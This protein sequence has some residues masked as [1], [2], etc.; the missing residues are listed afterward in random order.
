M[1]EFDNVTIIHA[2]PRQMLVSNLGASEL[3]LERFDGEAVPVNLLPYRRLRVNNFER[4]P[5]QVR[6]LDGGTGCVQVVSL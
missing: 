6:V 1:I 3:V 2:P 4:H 5:L